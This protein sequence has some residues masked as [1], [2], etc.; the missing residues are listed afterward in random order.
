MVN[1]GHFS[2]IYVFY[3]NCNF[4]YAYFCLV[5]HSKTPFCTMRTTS[6]KKQE[7][8]L[9]SERGFSYFRRFSKVEELKLV[10]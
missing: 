2:I 1:R 5:F 8:P 9:L 10:R 7:S 3:V 6:S 4:Y